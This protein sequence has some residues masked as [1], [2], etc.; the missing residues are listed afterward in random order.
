LRNPKLSAV[1]SEMGSAAITKDNLPLA[2]R[3]A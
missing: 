2:A 3:K 1:I